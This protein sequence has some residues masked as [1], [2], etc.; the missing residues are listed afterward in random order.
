MPRYDLFRLDKG[1]PIWVGTAES[2]HEANAHAKRLGDCPECVV[3]DQTTGE[4]IV[5]KAGQAAEPRT[6]TPSSY[7]HS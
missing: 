2:I 7:R 6:K 5:I 3:L 4:K 1:S